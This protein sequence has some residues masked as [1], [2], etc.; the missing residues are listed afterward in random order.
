MLGALPSTGGATTAAVAEVVGG[1]QQGHCFHIHTYR[2][3]SVAQASICENR[4]LAR[5]F[6][7]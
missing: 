5:L 2:E 3:T 6:V 4:T 7:L 1:K